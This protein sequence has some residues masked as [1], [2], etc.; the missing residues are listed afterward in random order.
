[1]GSN[2]N[3]ADVNADNGADDADNNADNDTDNN[4]NSDAASQT[5]THLTEKRLQGITL[6][7]TAAWQ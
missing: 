1:V 4:A 6:F 7:S 3:A 5:M 2:N